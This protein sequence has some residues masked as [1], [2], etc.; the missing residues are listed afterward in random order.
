MDRILSPATSKFAWPGFFPLSIPG[1]PLF[2]TKCVYSR[3]PPYVHTTFLRHEF[4]DDSL[5]L[6][7]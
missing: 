7:R 4:C 2:A 5:Y 1:V 3:L 6:S